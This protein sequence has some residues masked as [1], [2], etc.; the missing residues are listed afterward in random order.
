MGEKRLLD[1]VTERLMLGRRIRILRHRTARWFSPPV[2]QAPG[3]VAA[4]LTRLGATPTGPL[5]R[6]DPTVH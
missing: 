6:G 5:R 1:V 2:R 4:P 3:D